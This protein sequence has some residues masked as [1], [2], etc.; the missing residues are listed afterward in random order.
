MPGR[1]IHLIGASAGG[2]ET[3]S[4]LVSGLPAD[5]PAALCVVLHLS[6]TGISALPQI[7]GRS[8]PL[9]AAHAQDGEP[10]RPG[11][12]YVPRRTTIC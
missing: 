1:D 12:V 6:P 4:R 10:I 8:G 3:L 7:L 9:P 5:L 2:V 11:R